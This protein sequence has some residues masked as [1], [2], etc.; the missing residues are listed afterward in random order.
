M[1]WGRG[2][3]AQAHD[4]DG[5]GAGRN[6][7][8]MPVHR[9]RKKVVAAGDGIIS[10]FFKNKLTKHANYGILNLPN[11]AILAMRHHYPLTVLFGDIRI[12][13][14]LFVEGQCS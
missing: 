7:S 12:R 5:R 2:L 14:F 3:A 9:G 4:H 13:G 6:T 1:N 8:S 11:N 10:K